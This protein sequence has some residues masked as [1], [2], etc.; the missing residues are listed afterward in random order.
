MIAVGDHYWG[1]A[2]EILIRASCP[3]AGGVG[4]SRE[5]LCG[6]LSGGT[7]LLGALRGRTSYQENDEAVRT[8]SDEFRKRFIAMAGSAQCKAVRD[9]LPDVYKRCAPIVE[10]GTR[11]LME[12]LEEVPEEE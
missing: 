12:L 7:I 3:F 10:Q 1:K 8:L 2:P 6:V 11:I 9:S 5:E 4:G